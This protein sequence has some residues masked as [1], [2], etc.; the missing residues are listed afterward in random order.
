MQYL[1]SQLLWCEHF[2]M[3]PSCC[4][5]PRCLH[6]AIRTKL[7]SSV[8]ARWTWFVAYQPKA[9]PSPCWLRLVVGGP[10]GFWTPDLGAIDWLQ[11]SRV[12]AAGA[13][14]PECAEGRACALKFPSG[15]K[16][17]A[18]MAAPK[19]WTKL[20]WKFRSRTI[21]WD[22]GGLAVMDDLSSAG[23]QRTALLPCA[24]PKP[25]LKFI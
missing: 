24:S 17:K 16:L 7:S 21:A 14:E 6:G 15:L 2:Q 19:G 22:L 23:R 5:L 25:V 9:A 18:W 12:Y 3:E 4:R 13:A 11:R 8:Q 10:R 1:R 20:V